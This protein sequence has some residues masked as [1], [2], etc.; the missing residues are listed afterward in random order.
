MPGPEIEQKSSTADATILPETV[1]ARLIKA[2]VFAIVGVGAVV[3][4]F[5]LEEKLAMGQEIVVPGLSALAYENENVVPNY[6]VFRFSLEEVAPK[7]DMKLD[8][9]EG[10]KYVFVLNEGKVWG[11]FVVSDADVNILAGPIVVMPNR[12]SFS[13]NFDGEKLDLSVYNGDVY[14]GFLSEGVELTSY[15]DS[16]NGIFINRLLVPRD[17][18]VSVPVQKVSEE[19]RPLL[20]AKLSKEFKYAAIPAAE[21]ES[22]WVRDN[23]SEDERL[24]ESFKQEFVSKTISRGATAEDGLL[25]NFVFWAEERLSFVPEKKFEIAYDHLFSY[26]DDAVYF[27]NDGQAESSSGS[28]QKFD[29]YLANHIVADRSQYNAQFDAYLD[30]LMLLDA[31]DKEF[32]VLIALLEKK[33]TEGRDVYDVVDRFWSFVYRGMD[34]SDVMAEV[35]LEKYYEYLEK[36]LAGAGDED[37]LKMYLGDQN[38]LFDNLFIRSSLFF[39]DKYFEMKN[40]LEQSLLAAYESGQL[41]EEWKQV[42]ISNKIVFL[43][44]LKRFFFDGLIEASEA[45]QIF[46]RLVAE[47][48]GLMP[49]DS[50]D[51]AVVELFESQLEDISDFWGY[52]NS[53]EYHTRL[54]GS[55]HEERYVVYLEERDKI[56]SFI[57]IQE[58]VLGD[59][60]VADGDTLD[61]ID[62]VTA[63]LGEEAEFSDVVV[64]EVESLDQRYVNVSAVVGGYPFKAVYDRDT[65]LLKDVV[66]FDE[67]ISERGIKVESLLPV[68]QAKFADLADELESEEEFTIETSAQRY[69]RI[70]VA[71]TVA[72]AGFEAEMENVAIVDAEKAIYRVESV[73]FSDDSSVIV[74]FDINMT[75]EIVNNIF[76]SM[77][78]KPAVLEG[79][80][81]LEELASVVEARKNVGTENEAD[82]SELQ[83]AD[84]VEEFSD[85]GDVF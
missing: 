24:M 73:K 59:A 9:V 37:L 84:G 33:F 79:E 57:N 5:F 6:G 14:L 43:K 46:S 77:S 30:K 48:D 16:Y 68:L 1:A 72:K 13:L 63:A 80:Y 62:E 34:E 55:T 58:D 75:G 82:I 51:L 3:G 76:L 66:A 11:N 67:E 12:A 31:Q 26:L 52:L 45:K 22:E 10:N 18:T 19:L 20:S 35:A 28:L 61:V 54:Y 56:W 27:A 23:I 85:P 40:V 71:E 83:P 4:N 81:T 29:S 65:G 39:R 15:T 60:E 53:P 42:F 78:G 70:F 21:R 7:P 74:T 50:S 38:Q 64:G 32:S 44:R 17:T 8:V 47:V 49:S 25:S 41:Q 2:L 36:M 69:A